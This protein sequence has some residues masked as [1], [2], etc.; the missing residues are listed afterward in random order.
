MQCKDYLV[1]YPDQYDKIW[2]IPST[3]T[4]VFRNKFEDGTI[5]TQAYNSPSQAYRFRELHNKKTVSILSYVQV[6]F[7]CNCTRCRKHDE[8]VDANGCQ[9]IHEFVVC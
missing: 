6:C 1:Q 7:S 3:C 8:Q 9:F 2:K 5:S 4:F